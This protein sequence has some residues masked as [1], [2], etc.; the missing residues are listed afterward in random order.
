MATNKITLSEIYTLYPFDSGK[1]AQQ[2]G[3]ERMLVHNLVVGQ[4][5][6]SKQDV[7]K[8]LAAISQYTGRN[9]TIDTV[10]VRC[11]VIETE[12]VKHE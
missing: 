10:Q 7:I 3:L 4:G 1:I 2:A 8:I 5:S 11:K 9:Y 6:I 12:E